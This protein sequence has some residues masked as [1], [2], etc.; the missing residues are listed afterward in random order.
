[1]VVEE[2][3]DRGHHPL[4]GR[5]AVGSKNRSL[6]VVK[7]FQPPTSR[8]ADSLPASGDSVGVTLYYHSP[9]HRCSASNN[10][11]S[12][13][14]FA[15]APCRPDHLTVVAGQSSETAT[16]LAAHG[17]SNTSELGYL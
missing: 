16:S 3:S 15:T 12:H 5:P 10:I 6:V 4:R 13:A 8:T 1:M 17:L 9:N 7:R 11:R 14:R 2:F